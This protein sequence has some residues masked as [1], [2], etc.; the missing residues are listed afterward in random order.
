MLCL[1]S[2]KTLVIEEELSAVDAK[3]IKSTDHCHG[4]GRGINSRI[5]QTA[6]CERDAFALCSFEIAKARAEEGGSDLLFPNF[7]KVAPGGETTRD[8]KRRE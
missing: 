5:F 4:R 6:R 8:V 3:K 1:P 7:Q 2:T